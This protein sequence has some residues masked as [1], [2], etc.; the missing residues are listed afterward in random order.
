MKNL[1]ERRQ[2]TVRGSSQNG[3]PLQS[4]LGIDELQEVSQQQISF[5]YGRHPEVLLFMCSLEVFFCLK[6]LQNAF[7]IQ[8]ASSPYRRPL[9]GLLCKEDI[10]RSSLYKLSQSTFCIKSCR[11]FIPLKNNE[12]Y[13][14]KDFQLM[15]P[16]MNYFFPITVPLFAYKIVFP[17]FEIKA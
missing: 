4:H 15:P 11:K 17:I 14:Q 3:R 10:S 7:D 16:T 5:R 2:K 8:Y 1:H 13:H 12:F 6:Y 9:D